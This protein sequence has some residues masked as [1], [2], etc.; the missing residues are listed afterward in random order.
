MKEIKLWVGEGG[1]RVNKFLGW[2]RKRFS[3][4]GLV[5]KDQ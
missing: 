1:L 2:F 4:G 3:S 5:P